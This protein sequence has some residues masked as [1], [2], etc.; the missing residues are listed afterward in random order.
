M[1]FEPKQINLDARAEQAASI[2]RAEQ[3]VVRA[4]WADVPSYAAAAY[5]SLEARFEMG[6]DV[7]SYAFWR[8][9]GDVIRRSAR[10]LRA[11]I[12][13]TL[14]EHAFAELLTKFKLSD[15]ESTT[16]LFSKS[17][18]SVYDTITMLDIYRYEQEV[19]AQALKDPDEQARQDIIKTVVEKDAL[20]K[21]GL[22]RPDPF[23]EGLILTDIPNDSREIVTPTLMEGV[24]LR[25]RHPVGRN[26]PIVEFVLHKAA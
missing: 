9:E 4:I 24:T 16:K 10:G 22:S 12:R 11:K 5:E 20:A 19:L 25:F 1:E 21:I 7:A 15:R 26:T 13:Q 17:P 18:E 6:Q 2:L 23:V 14:V 3:Q 8:N